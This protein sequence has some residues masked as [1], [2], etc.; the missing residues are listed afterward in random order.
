VFPTSGVPERLG[1]VFIDLGDFRA[2]F[3]TAK[4]DLVPRETA[5]KVNSPLVSHLDSD[6]KIDDT[7]QAA[8]YDWRRRERFHPK[9]VK[10]ELLNTVGQYHRAQPSRMRMRACE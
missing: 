7:K 9:E 1:E 10:N 2:A 3:A 6:N 5:H 8:S 4:N